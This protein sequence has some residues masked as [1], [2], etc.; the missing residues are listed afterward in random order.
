MMIR[1]ASRCR[2]VD[3]LVSAFATRVDEKTMIVLTD[4]I[5]PVGARMPFA[6]ELGD[7]TV[8]M[9]GEAEV[10]EARQPPRGPTQLKLGLLALDDAGKLAHRRMLDRK[11]GV[12]A[13]RID[14]GS[15]P[16]ARV[17]RPPT[18]PPLMTAASPV[19][20]AATR[21]R[22][23]SGSMPAMPRPRVRTARPPPPAEPL[24]FDIEQMKALWRI[25]PHGDV[26]T[27]LH[28]LRATFASVGVSLPRVIEDALG[29]QADLEERIEQLERAVDELQREVEARAQEIARLERDH[30]ETTRVRERLEMAERRR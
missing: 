17:P 15:R 20:G 11:S 7:G 16:I 10:L 19:I 26:A 12:V 1:V 18:T 14:E 28:T 25:L 29:H 21:I 8:A 13:E 27:L 22:A 5:Y 6:I 4:Q 2:T 24:R 3:E 23:P 30:A 9:A